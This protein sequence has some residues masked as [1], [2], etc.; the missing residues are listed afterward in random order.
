MFSNPGSDF[1]KEYEILKNQD[2]Y[3]GQG[4]FGAVFMCKNK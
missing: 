4:A 2:P 1:S 3:L